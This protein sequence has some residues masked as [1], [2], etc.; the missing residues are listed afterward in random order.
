MQMAI[1]LLFFHIIS[2]DVLL[3]H[4]TAV[5]DGFS[6]GRIYIYIKKKPIIDNNNIIH[7]PRPRAVPDTPDEQEQIERR[8][9]RF[10]RIRFNG[11]GSGGC[12]IFF[13]R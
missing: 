4:K 2:C 13:F 12:I 6:R 11:R 7:L 8:V 3:V 1:S 9:V 5:G 10:M